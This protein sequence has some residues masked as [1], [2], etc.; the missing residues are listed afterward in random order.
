MGVGEVQGRDH[1]VWSW[2]GPS[3][4]ETWANHWC[5]PVI[6]PGEHGRY[7]RMLEEGQQQGERKQRA[8]LGLSLGPSFRSLDISPGRFG[9]RWDWERIWI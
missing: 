3:R 1:P 4:L 6:T 9:L 8:L 2:E 5:R 7:R